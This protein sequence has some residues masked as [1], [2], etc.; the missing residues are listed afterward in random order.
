MLR[1]IRHHLFALLHEICALLHAVGWYSDICELIIVI[2]T[3]TN[4]CIRTTFCCFSFAPVS[5]LF[6]SL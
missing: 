3:Y 6:S 4:D 2:V 5:I 1:R